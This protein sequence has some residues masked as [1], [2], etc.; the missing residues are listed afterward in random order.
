MSVV[1]PQQIHQQAGRVPAASQATNIEQARAIA[2]VQAMFL[3]AKQCPRDEAQAI[4]RAMAACGDYSVAERAFYSFKRGDS[5]VTD[6]SI[7]MAT[8]LARCWGNIYYGIM[9]LARDDVAGQ[10]EMLAFA[11]DLE[12]NTRSG[13]T[14]FVPHARDTKSGRRTLLDMRDIYENN[15]NNGSRRL[16]EC[17]FRVLPSYL[18]TAAE[19]RCRAVLEKGKGDKPIEVRVAEAI[20]AFAA[21]GINQERLEVKHGRS[22]KWTGVEIANLEIAYRSIRNGETTADEAFP[23]VDT[24]A[25]VTN[26]VRQSVARGKAAKAESQAEAD[27]APAASSDALPEWIEHETRLRD[28]VFLAADEDALKEAEADFLK[29]AKLFPE[30]ERAAMQAE[31]DQA[32]KALQG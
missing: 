25:T 15:A 3:V 22:T 12:T 23:P 13:Q 24:T 20:A 30:K 26:E 27:P 28:A 17:I 11:Q 10:T 8:E 5:I 4:K 14:F 7:V 16:R 29:V 2:E 18:K 21:V 19:E 32:F 9:E 6:K 1:T 31:I